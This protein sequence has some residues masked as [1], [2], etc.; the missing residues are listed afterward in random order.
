MNGNLNRKMM[1]I[2]RTTKT[3]MKTPQQVRWRMIQFAREER[4]ETG[5]YCQNA[6]WAIKRRQRI[7]SQVN[8]RIEQFCIVSGWWKLA[9]KERWCSKVTR[10]RGNRAA[11]Q[12]GEICKKRKATAFSAWWPCSIISMPASPE[13]FIWN[14]SRYRNLSRFGTWKARAGTWGSKVVG[15]SWL[16]IY[17]GV[18]VTIFLGLGESQFPWFQKSGKLWLLPL[19]SQSQTQ[20]WNY[21]GP[22]CGE[23]SFTALPTPNVKLL[24]STIQVRAALCPCPSNYSIVHDSG[25]SR[26]EIPLIFLQIQPLLRTVR[27]YS[28]KTAGC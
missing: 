7:P 10:Q 28:W 3:T 11:G 23:C 26:A 16:G 15:H 4:S 6:A 13:L 14:D 25:L 1:R 5:K 17:C 21:E 27:H 2:I 9:N 18:L 24:L 19:T 20:P 12:Q 22:G 8:A